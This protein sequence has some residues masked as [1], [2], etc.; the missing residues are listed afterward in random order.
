MLCSFITDLIAGEVQCG[1]GLCETI[2]MKD[3][4]KGYECYIVFFCRA[5]QRCSAPSSVT[6]LRPR[7][8]VVMIYVKQKEWDSRERYGCYIVLLQSIAK[9]LCCLWADAIVFKVQC[10][11]DLC[12]TK[13]VRFYEKIGM[14]HCFVVEHWQGFVLRYD[15]SHR[16]R[17]A[18]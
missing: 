5:L 17:C 15:W 2:A 3:S 10:G 12:E 16:S 4:M 18:V 6:R 13:T 9:M 1:E 7:F 8:T 11:E 14:L